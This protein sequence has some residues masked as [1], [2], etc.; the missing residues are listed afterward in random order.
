M[1]P[2]GHA[3]E[4]CCHAEPAARGSH[5]ALEYAVD[6]QPLA[7]RTDVLSPSEPE[8][9][10]ARGDAQAGQLGQRVDQLEATTRALYTS[11]IPPAP[12]ADVTLYGPSRVP[13]PIGMERGGL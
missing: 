12:S 5:T 10:R 2:V 8:R 4:L 1:I 9:R 3:R 7:D 13:D 11:P 6:T